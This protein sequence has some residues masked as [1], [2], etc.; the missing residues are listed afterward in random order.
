MDTGRRKA[1]TF[2]RSPADE[3][4]KLAMLGHPVT[5]V[6]CGHVS[7]KAPIKRFEKEHDI[8]SSPL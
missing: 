8:S 1:E 7:L 4:P 3:A 5:H 2:R 6:I